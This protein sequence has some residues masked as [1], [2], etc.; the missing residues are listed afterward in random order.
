LQDAMTLASASSQ[1]TVTVNGS[2]YAETVTIA[3]NIKFA[4]TASVNS[5]ILNSGETIASPSTVISTAITVNSGAKLQHAM[6]LA[7]SSAQ[8]TITAGAA[9]YAETV[10]INRSVK[11]VGTATVT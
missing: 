3:K 5:F 8:T 11:F 9:S 6:T 4:G 2:S 7:S 1:T 10:T